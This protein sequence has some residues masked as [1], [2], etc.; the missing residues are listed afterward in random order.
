[1]RSCLVF[2][3]DFETEGYKKAIVQ[4]YSVILFVRSC[5]KC[6]KHMK[7]KLVKVY[8]VQIIFCKITEIY[9]TLMLSIE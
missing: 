3:I 2:P 6:Y 9:S 1:M 4:T 8:L 7:H 5:E